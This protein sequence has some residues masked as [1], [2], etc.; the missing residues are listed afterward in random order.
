M[1][2]EGNRWTWE[3]EKPEWEPQSV[4]IDGFL[5]RNPLEYVD[6]TITDIPLPELPE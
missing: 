5:P 4:A 3:F 1:N 2:S 6:M